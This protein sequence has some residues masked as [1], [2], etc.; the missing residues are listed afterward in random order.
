MQATLDARDLH[1]AI[2]RPFEMCFLQ[3][4]TCR[5]L[6]AAAIVAL[7]VAARDVR[8]QEQVDRAMIAR[9]R[10]EEEQRSQV[11]ETYRT[12]TDVIGPRLTGTP[13]FKR[14]V[15]WTRGKL[16]E[17]GMSNVVVEPFPFGRGW[18]LQK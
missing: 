1:T 10:A 2:R 5:A 4:S 3:Y 6:V 17:W 9:L 8:A 18:T 11:L 16:T 13:G 15:D 14:S 12:L 7:P